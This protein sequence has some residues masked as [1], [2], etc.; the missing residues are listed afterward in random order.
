MRSL[1]FN[2]HDLN[3]ILTFAGFA[4]FTSI[5]DSISSIAYRGFALA[6]ALLCLINTR[7]QFKKIPR[8][9]VLLLVLIVVLDFKTGIHLLLDETPYLTS[10]YLALLFVF[11]ITLVPLL[12]FASGYRRIHWMQV[13]FVLEILLVFTVLKGLIQTFGSTED[14]R[15]SLNARQST[16]AFG[17]NSGYLL[18]LSTCLFI[19][20]KR[21]KEKKKRRIG[22]LLLVLAMFISVFGIARA[23]SRGPFLA[24]LLGEVFIFYTLSI[25]KKAYVL[26]VAA[27]A[28]LFFGIT[29]SSLRRFAPV[30]YSRMADTIEEGDMN[31]RQFLFSQAINLM[32]KYPISGDNPIIILRDGF[33]TYHN[34][35]LDVGVCLGWIGF[36]FYVFLSIWIA[37]RLLSRRHLIISVPQLFCAAQ[38]FLSATRAMTGATLLSNSNYALSIACACLVAYQLSSKEGTLFT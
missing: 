10:K 8:P 38:F 24:A 32:K 7:L 11:C 13:L 17:D 15:F 5:T 34:G 22:R 21:A 37:I 18:L 29:G 26:V 2:I 9:L 33:T 28:I 27:A 6:I 30:L 31:G 36:F 19:Y 16:L 23:G 1:K 12:A 4:I 20:L 14:V 35:Y 3:F 25:R